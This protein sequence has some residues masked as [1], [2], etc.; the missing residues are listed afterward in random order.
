MNKKIIRLTESDLNKM[1]ANTVKNVL[2]REDENDF[3]YYENQEESKE[4]DGEVFEEVWDKISETQ[5]MIYDYYES[6]SAQLDRD[7][8]D[9]ETGTLINKL[10]NKAMELRQIAVRLGQK[11]GVLGGY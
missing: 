2:M 3:D 7:D 6:M 9:P 4:F 5:D 1:I 10:N 11:L 8:F